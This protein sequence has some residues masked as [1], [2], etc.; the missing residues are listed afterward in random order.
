MILRRSIVPAAFLALAASLSGCAVTRPSTIPISTRHILPAGAG[1]P[2][3]IVLLHGKG[4]APQDFEKAR[5]AAIAQ[6]AGVQVD[7]VV[8]D[9]HEGY[10][11]DRTILTRLREDIVAPARA[12]G[13]KVW[14]AGVSMGG[15]GAL[16]YEKR[17]PGELQGVLALAPFLGKKDEI[18]RIIDAGGLDAWSPGDQAELFPWEAWVWLKSRPGTHAGDTPIYI[19]Y[20]RSDRFA[21]GLP[22]LAVALPKERLW[23]AEGGHSWSAWDAL[24]ERFLRSGVLNA[25]EK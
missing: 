4:G 14:L 22:L 11:D 24:W 17:Y 13:T 10:Y 23:T 6:R 9:A 7:L 12:G 1:S 3:L 19:G 2:T 5:F 21:G 15:T 20:G 8:A 16:L 25:R 18:R